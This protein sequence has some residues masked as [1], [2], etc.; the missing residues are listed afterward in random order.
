MS[1][2]DGTGLVFLMSSAEIIDYL[3]NTSEVQIQRADQRLDFLN[4]ESAARELVGRKKIADALQGLNEENLDQ[5]M[6]RL[7]RYTDNEQEWAFL[8]RAEQGRIEDLE[9]EISELKGNKQ[10]PWIKTKELNDRFNLFGDC[11]LAAARLC[12]K[13]S[14]LPE[15]RKTATRAGKLFVLTVLAVEKSLRMSK[16]A[17][18]H[19]RQIQSTYEEAWALL[20]TLIDGGLDTV[21]YGYCTLEQ[22]VDRSWAESKQTDL[23]L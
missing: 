8:E 10:T 22:R 11:A 23:P 2:S 3:S 6:N 9:A 4:R 16:E 7:D 21:A 20:Q 15:Y 5:V 19:R 12:N 13:V 18:K 17:P 14:A 1:S